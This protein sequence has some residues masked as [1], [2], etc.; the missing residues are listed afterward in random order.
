MTEADRISTRNLILT[1]MFTA[2]I[3]VFSQI[4]IPLQ[5]I[6]FSLSLLA[7]LLTGAL[8]E[9]RYALLSSLA[10]ILL[11]AFGLPVFAG[12]KGGIHILAGMTGGFI[13]AY[14]VMSFITSVSYKLSN[15]LSDKLPKKFKSITVTI[16]PLLGMIISLC[17]CYIAGTLWFCHVSGSKTAYALSVCV[18]PFVTFDL[19]KILMA[20]VIS[21]VLR[22]V[23]IK[24]R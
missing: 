14:P 6:P 13:M 9:P 24:V 3:C 16:L 23:M 21:A 10:Y 1:G 17:T 2:V 11:G 15:K 22:K 18:L 8:L 7:I 19:L 12:F 5:P 20:A 4:V